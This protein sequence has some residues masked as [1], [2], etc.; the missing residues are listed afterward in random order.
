VIRK[1]CYEACGLYRFGLAQLA[2]FDMWIRLCLKY[3]IHVLPEKLTKFRVL[4]NEANASGNRPETRIRGLYEGY[5]LLSN[6][7]QVSRIE[8]LIKIFPLAA[9]FDRGD[10][11]DLD[12]VLAMITLEDNTFTFT[13]LF[14]LDLL[15]SAI[16]DSKR[17]EVIKRLYDFDYKSFIALTAQYDVFS[18]E[19]VSMLWHKLWARDASIIGLNAS[20]IGL[21]DETVKRG[22]W[23][24]RLDAELK[25]EHARLLDIMHS[26]SWQL[27]LPLRK[28]RIWISNLMQET[29]RCLK[30][31]I[32]GLY[33]L[34]PFS[35]SAKK[36]MKFYLYSRMGLLFRGMPGYQNWE[37]AQKKADELKNQDGYEP[38]PPVLI[39]IDMKQARTV[40]SGLNF[41][42]HEHPNVSIIIPVFNGL[43]YTLCCLTSIKNCSSQ[44]TFE[45]IIID[46]GS[47][48]ETQRVISSIQN[49]RYIKNSNNLGFIRSCNKAA[50]AARGKYLLFLNNDTQ[51]MPNWLDALVDT[52]A[53]VPDAGLVG[54]KLIYPDGRL[55]EAG[56][57]I[58][59]D[60]SG[61][62]YG[63]SD[64][65]LRPEY[66]YLREVDYCSGASLMLPKELFHEL[67]AFDERYVPAYYEDADLAFAVRTKGKKVL[68]QPFSQ[69]IHFEG[70]SSGT[71]IASGT[72]AFQVKNKLKFQ[73]KWSERLVAHRLPGEF[74]FLEKDRSVR[75]R[76]LVIDA[77]TLTPDKDAGSLLAINSYKIFIE[78]GYKVSFFPADLHFDPKYTADLQAIGVECL[79]SPYWSSIASYLD[80]YG[81]YFDIV[82]LYRAYTAW[83]HI[84]AVRKYCPHAKVIFNT[85]D[86][87]FLREERQA[88]LAGSEELKRQAAQTKNIEL[89]VMRTADLSIVLST[90][91]Y[92]L[93]KKEDP[94]LRLVTIPLLM[95]TYGNRTPFLQ[96]HDIVFIGGYEHPPNID[97]VKYF[98]TSI[99][100]LVHA[101]LPQAKFIMLGSKMPEDVKSLAAQDGVVAVG[102]VEDV[103]EY[104]DRCRVSVAPLRFGA[105]IKGKIA[106]SASYGLPCV[107]TSLAVEGMGVIHGED[108]LVADSDEEFAEKVIALYTEEQQWIHISSNA[109][110]FI[111][112]NYSLQAGKDK[113][114]KVFC[115]LNHAQ[116]SGSE[117]SDAEGVG[118][119]VSLGEYRNHVEARKALYTTRDMFSLSLLPPDSQPF[120]IP[121]YCR[122]CDKKTKFTVD[123]L[124]SYLFTLEGKALPN[125]RETVV[126]RHCGLNNRLRASLDIFLNRLNSCSAH[127]IYITEQLTPMYSLLN[128]RYPNVTGSEYL[129]DKL[130][131]GVTINGIRHE[132]LTRLSFKSNSLDFILSFDVFEHVPHY[133]QAFSECFRCL[134]VGGAMLFSVPFNASAQ[135]TLVRA[136]IGP[137]GNIEHLCTPEYHGNPV[138]PEE[139]SLCF[140]HFG[141][142]LIHRLK[143]SGFVESYCLTIYSQQF[144]YIGNEQLLF[145]AK[146]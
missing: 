29:K 8:D 104:F 127:N 10:E 97:A 96:R 61:W 60:G 79:Y 72:K 45:I 14:G 74:P 82:V 131:P 132:D 71:D 81:T 133:E 125:W 103:G 18:R 35:E 34:L 46:D 48:D 54:S 30:K 89:T 55:Q 9:K 4:D 100:P 47:T 144:G 98:V 93:L 135:N 106:T 58:W 38:K 50:K 5:K 36:K 27:T 31:I 138:K 1:S 90:T 23:A 85:V 22:E 124:N 134:K 112:N 118:K 143:S 41:V 53:A 136:R 102:Y 94:T 19:E 110:S 59:N 24:L 28:A 20:I 80:K 141:W 115:S 17:S 67:G 42:Y 3:E 2:D 62:N 109:L 119:F 33:R 75:G 113:Y 122:I 51:V 65:P 87:H 63:N 116:R 44:N 121:G 114:I 76:M 139:G 16:S 49:I 120:I 43:E 6:Y 88:A 117:F 101:R 145:V 70:I 7:R 107:A 92:D 66:N 32:H 128:K 73:D 111:E 64:D 26:N 86:L 11:T 146:K 68:Y 130:T 25:E 40:A 56:G 83:E 84:H 105:G 13:R 142:D 69:V 129:G 52:F 95:Q 126:C 137:Q 140:Y 99:W 108:I 21:T 91:E 12:F 123:Y 37:I 77:T 78:L 39:S 57:I 15:F